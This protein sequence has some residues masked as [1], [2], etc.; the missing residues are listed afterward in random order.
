MV[1]VGGKVQLWNRLHTVL[2]DSNE[3]S[4]EGRKLREDLAVYLANRREGDWL[5][6]AARKRVVGGASLPAVLV[7]GRAGRGRGNNNH[8][9]FGVVI[10]EVLGSGK[11]SVVPW[12]AMGHVQAESRQSQSPGCLS[13]RAAEG[14]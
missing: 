10:C 3:A 11:R 12:R 7:K 6:V 8:G 1:D 13:S 4:V 14:M 2:V 5:G 9:H